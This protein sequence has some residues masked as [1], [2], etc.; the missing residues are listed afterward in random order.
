[1]KILPEVKLT[2]ASFKEDIQKILKSLAEVTLER[3]DLRKT[4]EAASWSTL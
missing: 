3:V 1:M 4:V 2:T